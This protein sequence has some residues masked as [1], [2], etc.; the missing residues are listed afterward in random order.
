MVGDTLREL[1]TIHERDKQMVDVYAC[2]T[3][4]FTQQCTITTAD[5]LNHQ[6]SK[7]DICD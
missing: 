3:V 5:S 4:H 6:H 7:L 2:G 1:D